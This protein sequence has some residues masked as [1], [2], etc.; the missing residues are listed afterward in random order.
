MRLF[1]AQGLR[2]GAIA[3]VVVAIIIGIR[4]LFPGTFVAALS[5]LWRAGDTVAASVGTAG[6]FFGNAATLAHE[7]DQLLA[8]RAAL[9]VE[10]EALRTKVA[11][12]TKL[13]GSRTEVEHGVIAGVLARPPVS[14]YD[15][16]VVDRGTEQGVIQGALVF[17]AGGIPLG[18][19]AAA[20]ANASRVLL[21]SAPGKETGA[22][23][24]AQK[25]PVTLVGQGSG[26]FHA[27]VPRDAQVVAG[28]EVYVPGPGAL[29]IGTVIEVESNPAATELW[30]SIRPMS[31]P[32][33]TTWVTISRHT[34]L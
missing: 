22:W 31:N 33:S 15:V 9:S 34:S 21:Y 13:L 3:I 27:K 20:T 6:S 25:L 30:V 1:T 17:G 14:P 7:R 2:G 26:A 29:P 16:L 4:A 19:V 24:G 10:N 5:P 23:I 8:E 32:F 11:D 12:L 18:T 28:D